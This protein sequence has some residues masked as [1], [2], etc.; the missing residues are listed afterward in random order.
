MLDKLIVSYIPY[1]EWFKMIHSRENKTLPSLTS[2]LICVCKT[3]LQ[4]HRSAFWNVYTCYSK[5]NGHVR[6]QKLGK[7][8]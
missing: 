3:A 5:Q 6:Y 8:Y 1:K 4:R 2:P 7:N